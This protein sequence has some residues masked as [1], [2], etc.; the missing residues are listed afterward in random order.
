MGGHGSWA[1]ARALGAGAEDLVWAFQIGFLSS[2]LFGLLAME[3]AEARRSRGK[4]G[5]CWHRCGR[6]GLPP[7]PVMARPSPEKAR[8][9]SSSEMRPRRH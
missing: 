2:L 3:V 5:T 7:P 8:A 4:G 6:P 1:I 9:R